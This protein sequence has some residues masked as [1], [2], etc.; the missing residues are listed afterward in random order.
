MNTT[1][2]YPLDNSN[3]YI[4]Y[5]TGNENISIFINIFSLPVV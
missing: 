4:N 2:F 3:E 5:T 1:L